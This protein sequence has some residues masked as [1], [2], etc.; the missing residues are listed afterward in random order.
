MK[1]TI[2]FNYTTALKCFF[3]LGIGVSCFKVRKEEKGE[4]EAVYVDR[5]APGDFKQFAE[6]FKTGKARFAPKKQ[7]IFDKIT[8]GFS[9][10]QLGNAG[11]NIIY[12]ITNSDTSAW[13]TARNASILPD[14]VCSTVQDNLKELYGGKSEL[15]EAVVWLN[16]TRGFPFL[17]SKKDGV[18]EPT[19]MLSIAMPHL[20]M[21]NDMVGGELEVPLGGCFMIK[22]VPCYSS[23]SEIHEVVLAEKNTTDK[24]DDILNEINPLAAPNYN[25]VLWICVP[26]GDKRDLNTNELDRYFYIFRQEKEKGKKVQEI[27]KAK[28]ALYQDLFN[29]FYTGFITAKKAFP[30]KRI[31][32]KI[33]SWYS[34]PRN[35]QMIL[36]YHI[37]KTACA[38]AASIAGVALQVY[39]DS[40][41]SIE[42]DKLEKDAEESSLTHTIKRL[43]EKEAWEVYTYKPLKVGG[44]S[45]A[46]NGSSPE[47]LIKA[48]FFTQLETTRNK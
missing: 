13:E 37:M 16:L 8:K 11:D 6:Y 46:V 20:L 25:H 43:N 29:A 19:D 21:F 22:N 1:S 39:A 36:L 3:L 48:G 44:G 14:L 2:L 35:H 34:A 41:S 30:N 18:L 23:P 42:P 28:L 4:S 27:T 17:H 5:S 47:Q 32:I 7:K 12:C 24:E 33:G 40:T 10:E 15:D 31:V 26:G 38:Q 9:A 45:V